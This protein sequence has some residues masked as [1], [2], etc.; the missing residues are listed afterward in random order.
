MQYLRKANMV[1]RVKEAAD[2]AGTP[3]RILLAAEK[4]FSERGIDAVG[5]REITTAAGVNSA[6]AHYYFGSKELLLEQLF[7]LRAAPIAAR[8]EE[9]LGNLKLD[10][11]GRPILEDVLTAFL[12][13]VLE[14]LNTPDS[15]AF[16]LLCARMAFEREDVRRV[17]LSKGF[18]RSSEMTLKE[19]ARALPKMP[20]E[21]LGWR[22]HFL[23]GSMVYTMA[24]PDRN[25]SLTLGKVN[26]W[27][28]GAA[29]EQ[30]V[31]FAAAGFRAP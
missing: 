12:C 23:L 10:K 27:E 7:A 17:G 30:M 15:L 25:E 13:P 9:L 24:M 19:L 4:L 6:A 29:L 2:P 18:N 20:A 11:E 3:G 21:V 5:L 22:F 14:V 31:R 8:R 28:P 1:K 16:S 26:Y